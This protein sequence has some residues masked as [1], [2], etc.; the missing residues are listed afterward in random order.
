MAGVCMLAMNGPAPA[1]SGSSVIYGINSAIS[2]LINGASSTPAGRSIIVL[3]MPYSP[4]ALA[5]A[6]A[7]STNIAADRRQG[8]QQ[9]RR[10]DQPLGDQMTQDAL[11]QPHAVD[12]A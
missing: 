2:A 12:A 9:V 5:D 7:A 8:A 1:P 10:V 4:R 3:L 11:L 6:F